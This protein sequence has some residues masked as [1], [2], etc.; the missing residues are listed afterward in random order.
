MKEYT[1]IELLIHNDVCSFPMYNYKNL[2]HTNHISNQ[3]I[4]P[5]SVTDSLD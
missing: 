4:F 2:K 5:R 1:C 3:T